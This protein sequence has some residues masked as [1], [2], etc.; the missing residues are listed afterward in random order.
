MNTLGTCCGVILSSLS[1]EVTSCGVYCC[2]WACSCDDALAFST[3]VR[4]RRQRQQR[5][6]G[7]GANV[8][9]GGAVVRDLWLDLIVDR[10]AGRR[11]DDLFI[12]RAVSQI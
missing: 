2:N 12:G 1:V 7:A 3:L 6:T 8:V 4:R 10:L 11:I 9:D 5:Q